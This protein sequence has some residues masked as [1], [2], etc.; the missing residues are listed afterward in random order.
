MLL[1]GGTGIWDKPV[2]STLNVQYV[3]KQYISPYA[4]KTHHHGNL[5]LTI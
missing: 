5:S 3:P 2:A 4:E 1:K